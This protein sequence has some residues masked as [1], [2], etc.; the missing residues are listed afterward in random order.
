MLAKCQSLIKRPVRKRIYLIDLNICSYSVMLS[1]PNCNQ[2]NYAFEYDKNK[3]FSN[4]NL[5]SQAWGYLFAFPCVIQGRKISSIIHVSV[6][7]VFRVKKKQNDI[8]T[9][10]S[11]VA[12]VVAK[13]KRSQCKII[14]KELGAFP[15][16]C[17]IKYAR[18]Y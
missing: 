8:E 18:F 17:A 12:V 13:L 1:V 3:S 2:S 9:I 14:N 10:L 11:L 15:F 5:A 6:F 7:S 4:D 16:Y